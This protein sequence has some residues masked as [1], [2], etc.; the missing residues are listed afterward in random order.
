MNNAAENKLHS[1]A[2][3][4]TYPEGQRIEIIDGH[5]YNMADAPTRIHQ[6]IIMELA[7]EI[8]NYINL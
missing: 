7:A 3:Y 5:I 4:L 2:D 1:Y 6:K 8:R